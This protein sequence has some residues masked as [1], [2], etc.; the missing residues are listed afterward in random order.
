MNTNLLARKIAEKSLSITLIA[1]E[2]GLTRQA[3]YNKLS[4]DREFKASEI[5]KLSEL[6]SLTREE[7]ELIFFADFVGKTAN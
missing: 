6:L 5:G 4:G 7:K 2:L 1:N 3:I